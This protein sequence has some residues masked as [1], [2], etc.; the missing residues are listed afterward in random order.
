MQCNQPGQF[1][2]IDRLWQNSGLS[3]TLTT[4]Q[5][6]TPVVAAARDLNGAGL[7]HGVMAAIE[8][9]AAGGAG[10][11]TYTLTYTD[12]SGNAG[13]TSTMV[14]MASPP[15]GT[16]EVFPWAAGDVGVRSIQS[17][18]ASATH[19]SGAFHLILFRL[20]ASLEVPASNVAS[21]ID[22]LTGGAPRIYDNSALG[23]IWWPS[24][25]ATISHIGSYIETQG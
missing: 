4:A 3:T 9:S 13:S 25:A 21:A 19:T 23:G 11:P 22:F 24:A 5:A 18:I 2:L 8:W 14:S 17:I 7:G 15:A 12:E 1:W 20:I 16:I 10:T 6:I